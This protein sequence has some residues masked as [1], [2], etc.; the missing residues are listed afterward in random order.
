MNKLLNGTYIT[1]QVGNIMPITRQQNDLRNPNSNDAK[2]NQRR[3]RAI[4]LFHALGLE[5]LLNSRLKKIANFF[6]PAKAQ[7]FSEDALE[8]HSS[9]LAAEQLPE[10]SWLLK[11]LDIVQTAAKQFIHNVLLNNI[12]QAHQN[13][14]LS[15]EA[16]KVLTP[17]VTAAL[18][19]A[20]LNT[21]MQLQNQNTP[22]AAEATI[23]NAVDELE[24]KESREFVEEIRTRHRKTPKPKPSASKKTDSEEY[25]EPQRSLFNDME[26]LGAIA[27][28]R[29]AQHLTREH[30]L[31]NREEIMRET[32][33]FLRNEGQYSPL[34]QIF[35][36][37]FQK[38]LRSELSSLKQFYDSQLPKISITTSSGQDNSTIQKLKALLDE[39]QSEYG[40]ASFSM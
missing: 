29:N 31:K 22:Q 9:E 15:N 8:S 14:S 38:D 13:G 4:F 35:R 30:G 17:S 12:N 37:Q 24:H 36:E 7:T 32:C 28:L 21:A 10:L 40:G 25:S 26:V 39:T 1:R 3:L 5:V 27:I 11:L 16:V 18:T 2:M 33:T 34:F 6:F 20:L 19:P 23:T